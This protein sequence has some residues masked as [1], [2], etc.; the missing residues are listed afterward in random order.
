[1]E[2]LFKMKTPKRVPVTISSKAMRATFVNCDVDYIK[3]YCK[4]SCCFNSKGIL[5]VAIALRE[6]HYIKSLGMKVKNGLL[7]PKQGETRC[8]FQRRNGLCKIHKRKPIGCAISP[9]NLTVNSIVIVRYRNLCMNC[10]KNGTIPAYKVFRKSLEAMFGKKETRGICEDLDD[11]CGDVQ[12]MMFG[13]V[14][15]DLILNRKTRSKK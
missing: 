6:E 4:G 14:W 10:F 9:F 2:E 1:M 11:G 8:P 12:A 5:N 15:E 13:D 7:Q 3:E